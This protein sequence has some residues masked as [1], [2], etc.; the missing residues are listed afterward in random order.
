MKEKQRLYFEPNARV[1]VGSIVFDQVNAVVINES[2]LNLSN[3]ATVTLP[4]NFKEMD[5]KSP[6][7]F[8]NVGDKVII[9]LGYDENYSV[10][11]TGYLAE[12]EAGIPLILHFDDEMYP[13]KQNRFKKTFPSIKLKELL[14]YIA[15]SYTIEC[16]DVELG[17]FQIANVSTFRV[18]EALQQQF[19]F[20][21]KLKNGVLR[22][23]YP[24]DFEYF[25]NHKYQFAVN[26]KKQEGL[27]WHRAEDVKI[28][29]K[30]IANQRDGEKL[31]Y[32]TGSED[33]DA[34][35]RTLNY[36][37]INYNELVER[38]EADY[39]RFAFDGYSGDVNGWGIPETHAG[40]ILTIIDNDE[41]EREGDYL[42]EKVVITYSLDQG[43]NRK[44]TLSYKV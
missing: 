27:T 30:G 7:D 25:Q 43:F 23:F 3:S 19:G 15:P 11:F 14:I 35:R 38:V 41:P 20:Y 26:I 32:E 9:E 2:V 42:I 44:N 24:F 34:S 10:E 21:T 8:M 18:L 17:Q 29:V 22:C 39:K 5:G 37:D 4:R 13:L 6:L 33:S 40:D 12:I 16:S 31:T 28:R 36:G 1:T